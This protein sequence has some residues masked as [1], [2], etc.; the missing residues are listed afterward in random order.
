MAI[1]TL[2]RKAQRH[3]TCVTISVPMSGPATLAIAQALLAAPSALPRL[4]GGYTTPSRTNGSVATAPAPMPWMARAP[5]NSIIVRA[6]AQSALP[7]VNATMPTRYVRRRPQ[8]SDPGPQ[9]GI[10]TAAASM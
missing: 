5:M 4:L 10:D 2:M 8:R 3:E 7:T 9:I 6:M 1:G